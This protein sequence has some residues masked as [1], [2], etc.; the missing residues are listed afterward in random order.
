MDPTASHVNIN[1][2]SNIIIFKGPYALKYGVTFGGLINLEI[3]KPQFYKSFEN[4]ISIYL[5]AQTN[6]EGYKSGIRVYGGN[7]SISYTLSTNK[8]K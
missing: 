3:F 5:G 8:N 2:L 4:H 7:S 6:H 1:D